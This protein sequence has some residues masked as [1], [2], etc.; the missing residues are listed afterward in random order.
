[1]LCTDGWRERWIESTYKGSEQGAWGWTAGKFYGDSERDKGNR[2]FI[3]FISVVSNSSCVELAVDVCEHR[4]TP[5]TA[6]ASSEEWLIWTEHA[7]HQ[8]ITRV[9]NLLKFVYYH[10]EEK[11]TTSVHTDSE[12]WQYILTTR[13]WAPA[14]F[15]DE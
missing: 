4:T 5:D 9:F 3:H 6:P 11:K 14:Q 12:A 8:S 13:I 15:C 10:Q 2:T 7:Y 1:L